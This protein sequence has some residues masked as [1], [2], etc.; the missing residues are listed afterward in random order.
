MN[1]YRL[2][3]IEARGDAPARAELRIYGDIGNW[4]DE[5]SPSARSV[6][7]QIDALTGDI[8]VHINSYGGSVADGVAIYNALRRYNKGAVTTHVD[9]VAY[10]IASLM[11]MAG[12]RVSMASNAMLMIHAPWVR[13]TGNAR[14]LRE[15]AA[16]LDKHAS[17]MLSSYLRSANVNAADIHTWLTDGA[18]HYLT[19]AEALAH[20]LIDSIG[21]PADADESLAASLRKTGYQLPA[22][23]ASARTAVSTTPTP[24]AT[25]PTQSPPAA[26]VAADTTPTATPAYP[27]PT[28]AE[29]E[30]QLQAGRRAEADRRSQVKNVFA[31]FRDRDEAIMKLSEQCIDDMT[32]TEDE[33]RRRLLATLAERSTATGPVLDAEQ[34]GTG[35]S[36][37]APPQASRHL[38]GA[39]PMHIIHDASDK[40][41]SAIVDAMIVRAGAADPET[42][43]R[44]DGSNP[45]RGATLLDLAKESAARAGYRVGGML[46]HQVVHAAITQG[47]SDFPVLLENV[48][49]KVLQA[50][51]GTQPDTWSRFCATGSVSDFRAHNRYRVGSLGNLDV[52]AEMGEFTNKAIPDGEK[53]S[54]AAVTKGNIINM[55]RQAIINDDLGAFVGAASMLGRAARRSIENDVYD[56]LKLNSGL[57]PTQSDSQPLFHSNR[58]NVGTSAA[59]STASWDEAVSIMASQRDISGNDYLDL[60][61]AVWVGPVG[62]RAA[63]IKVNEAEFDETAQKTNRAPNTAR[64]LVRDIVASPR[65]SGNRYYFFADPSVAPV[66]EVAFL[67]GIQEPYLERQD[68]FD[69]DG[70]RYKVRIDYGV[71]VI[72][73]RGAVTNQGG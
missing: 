59:N 10:S 46:P 42:R 25:M 60:A 72:D 8:D 21:P 70:V 30:Q 15:T 41:A 65:L 36:T 44:V 16:M 4:W 20:G 23:R 69:V 24:E 19:A 27:A 28:A 43:R 50:A 57:G 31:A 56:L 37:S 51:Y 9:G 12:R 63:A 5:E 47:T 26:P 52:V 39:G 49:H 29:L 53:S 17:A 11:A 58:A 38:G 33:A 22:V 7:E 73:Y 18:D 1:N 40:R 55:S 32:C 71:A 61:P 34:Y 66:I 3:Q 68:G 14:D 67:Q 6:A 54:I 62:L 48:M 2:H 45:W 13:T 35:H 64:G